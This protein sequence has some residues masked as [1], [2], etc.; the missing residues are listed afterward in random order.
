[1]VYVPFAVIVMIAWHCACIVQEYIR[2]GGSAITPQRAFCIRFQP[3]R[4]DSV[5]N[6]KLIYVWVSNNRATSFTL[7]KT[8]RLTLDHNDTGKCGLFE[9]VHPAIAIR[10]CLLPPPLLYCHNSHSALFKLGRSFFRA[11]YY[12]QQTNI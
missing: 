4:H 10:S 8:A 5:P 2:N 3:D 6:R 7:K 9:S 11:L 1:M 12:S